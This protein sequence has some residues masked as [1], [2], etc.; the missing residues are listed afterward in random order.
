MLGSAVLELA[1]GMI[2]VYLLLSIVASA[3]SGKI[4]EILMWRSR[5]LEEGMRE[6]IMSGDWQTNKPFVK[7]IVNAFYN[8]PMIKGLYRDNATISEWLLNTPMLKSMRPYIT[9]KNWVPPGTIDSKTFTLTL[10]DIVAPNAD[11]SSDVAALQTAIKNA[12]PLQGTKLQQTL[13]SLVG[14]AENDVTSA[15]K[16]IEDWFDATMEQITSLYTKR[17]RLISFFVGLVVALT[18]NVDTIAVANNLWRDPVVRSAVSTAAADYAAAHPSPATNQVSID[19]I[20]QQFNGLNLPVG[21]RACRD[22]VGN[23]F[24]FVPGDMYTHYSTPTRAATEPLTPGLALLTDALKVMGWLISG[25][26]AAQG[27]PF[28]YDLLKK[29]TAMGGQ[30][31]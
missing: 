8:H 14:T 6:L 12:G 11:K 4:S 7:G 13:L 20:Q 28:W 2:F 29:A 10:M 9:D 22:C 21:W 3:I 24:G 23:I 27:A 30:G 25:L 18:F 31:K 26:A 16:N 17:M 19:A 1:V 15:R 5:F